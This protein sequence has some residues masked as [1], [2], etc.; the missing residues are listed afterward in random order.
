MAIPLK[1]YLMTYKKCKVGNIAHFMKQ[2]ESLLY[3]V[4]WRIFS[5]QNVRALRERRRR[6]SSSWLILTVLPIIIGLFDW[7]INQS[8]TWDQMN[9]WCQHTP[10]KKK[11]SRHTIQHNQYTFVQLAK[12][13]ECWGVYYSSFHRWM[14]AFGNTIQ[15]SSTSKWKLLCIRI[16]QSWPRQMKLNI[17]TIEMGNDWEWERERVNIA[18]NLLKKNTH[19]QI[20]P[21]MNGNRKSHNLSLIS[22]SFS[23]AARLV[24]SRPETFWSV[25]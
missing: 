15:S 10:K 22:L 12:C 14:L 13:P 17:Y 24:C 6:V 20:K 8:V 7:T 11:Q 3:L 21:K 4:G 16:I 18:H 25:E 2:F 9:R 5:A 1:D 19:T 23:R